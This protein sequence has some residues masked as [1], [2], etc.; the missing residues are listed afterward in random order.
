MHVV[1]VLHDDYIMTTLEFKVMYEKAVGLSSRQ[2]PGL[3]K[4]CILSYNMYSTCILIQ[5][6]TMVIYVCHAT[7]FIYLFYFYL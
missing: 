7:K 5:L 2:R 6:V 3:H 4:T 1:N